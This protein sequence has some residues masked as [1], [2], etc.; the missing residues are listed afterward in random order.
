MLIFILRAVLNT[1]YIQYK[2]IWMA[3][4]LQKHLLEFL[5]CNLVILKDTFSYEI[6]N[7]LIC[8]PRFNPFSTNVSFLYPLKILQNIRFPEVFRGHRSGTWVE[9]LLNRN[10]IHWSHLI[11]VSEIQLVLHNIQFNTLHKKWSFPLRISSVN[12][13]KSAVSPGFGHIYWKNP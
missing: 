2:F 11:L 1:F 12:V 5:Y 9:N 7:H 6:E 4:D 8:Q 10:K 13:T 3:L